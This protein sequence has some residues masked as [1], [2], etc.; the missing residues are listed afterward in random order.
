MTL[1]PRY[2]IDFVECNSS[3]IYSAYTSK[4]AGGE[5]SLNV[6]QAIYQKKV[7]IQKTLSKFYLAINCGKAIIARNKT[8]FSKSVCAFA[9]SYFSTLD[10]ILAEKDRYW[11]L[12]YENRNILRDFSK[13][14]R[15]GEIA[16]GI[17]YLFFKDHMGAKVIYDF[18]GYIEDI[19]GQK[20][21]GLG[22]KPDYVMVYNNGM[23]G[24]MESKGTAEANPTC[25]M[26]SGYGQIMNG[27]DYLKKSGS[28]IRNG[29]VSAVSFGTTSNSLSR[30][31]TVYY[32]D[33]EYYTWNNNMVSKEDARHYT[34]V[35]SSKFAYIA[36]N[37]EWYD[38]LSSED[39]GKRL[40]KIEGIDRYSDCYIGKL[41]YDGHE[42]KLGYQNELIKTLAWD[43]NYP[44]FKDGIEK[45]GDIEREYYKDGTFIEYPTI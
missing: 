35:E 11:A 27:M 19:I 7:A 29:F 22:R 13:S 25:R 12:N 6:T 38:A 43:E 1:N 32:A 37:H 15:I 20:P 31:T 42:I 39:E 18:D 30:N 26:I 44:E 33:P 8:G 14:S 24:V 34:L 45:L 28:L 4:A 10:F 41:E 3:D 2:S 5:H 17:N 16:Q 21:T 23:I 9:Q 36:G 40:R